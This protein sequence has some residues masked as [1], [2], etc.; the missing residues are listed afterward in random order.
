MALLSVAVLGWVVLPVGAGILMGTLLAFTTHGFHRA[1]VRRTGRRALASLA[2]TFAATLVVAGI[3][4]VLV[5]LLVVQGVSVVSHA[6]EW[7]APGGPAASLIEKTARPLSAF[8]LQPGDVLRRL[9]DALGSIASSLAGWAAQI[10]GM[11]MDGALA[12]FFM[13]I[14]MYFVLCRWREITLRA[15]R[16][17]PINPH[18]TRHLMREVRRLGRT[19]VIGNFGTAIAQGAIAGVGYAIAQLPHPAFFGAITAVASLLPVF[20]TMLV[21]L[22]AGLFLIGSGRAGLGVFE[23]A[24]AVVAVVGSCDYFIRP[25]LVGRDVKSSSWLTFVALFGGVKLFG[26]IGLVL[27]PLLVGIAQAVLRLY[28]RTRRFRLGLS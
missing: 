5:S 7:F 23:I 10:V 6:H 21:W 2:T 25:W 3:L 1:I 8:Q 18:H 11:V 28:E 17:L 27:G 9:R 14:T 24:W 19:V 26:I 13:A 15:E 4:G 22:P 12:L 16:L 20:G